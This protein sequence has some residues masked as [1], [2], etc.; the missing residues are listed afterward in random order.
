MATSAEQVQEIEGDPSIAFDCGNRA[1]GAGQPA[2]AISHYKEALVLAPG[3]HEIYNNLATAYQAHGDLA[4]AV[5]AA[6]SGLQVLESFAPLHNTLANCLA[7]AGDVK[8]S[9]THYRRALELD[10]NFTSAE[11]N[12]AYFLSSTGRSAAARTLLEAANQRAPGE[13]DVLVALGMILLDENKQSAGEEFLKAALDL[14]PRHPIAANQL[15]IFLLSRGRNLEALSMFQELVALNPTR[16]KLQVNLGLTLQGLARN[17]EAADV[18]RLAHQLDP[19]DHSMLS[20]YMQ[21]LMHECAWDE[22]RPIAH[23]VL[24]YL[25]G[26]PEENIEATV[27]PFTLA[28]T[29][30]EPELQLKIARVFSKRC[31]NHLDNVSPE[32]AKV[33]PQRD[34]SKLRIGYVSPDFRNHSLGSSFLHLLASHDTDRFEW[35]GYF[36]GGEQADAGTESFKLLFDDWR[37]L[38]KMSLAASSKVIR[39]DGLDIVVDLAGHTKQSGLE[40]FAHNPAPIQAHYL[41]YGCTIGADCIHYLITDKVHT[42]IHLAEFCHE[43]LVYLPDSFFATGRPDIPDKQVDR[44]DFDLPEDAFVFANFGNHYKLAPDC[45]DTWLSLLRDLPKSVLWLMDGWPSATANLL[46]YTRNHGVEPERIV[47]G[48]RLDQNDHLARLKLADLALDTRPE[49]DPIS[50]DTELA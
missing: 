24:E 26:Q 50:L 2:L 5:D 7:A 18:F 38:R 42:P 23:K 44:R 36:I 15:A 3:A 17:A 33:S 14:S 11:V 9:E 37:D 16:A 6:R 40:I 10:P 47:F 12:F 22:L 43:Q 48:H 28:G 27:T 19:N 45:F 30:A 20:F 8:G 39:E 34:R 13:V 35:Y 41:G 31:L 32:W 25:R 46:N 29:E 21:S 49:S 1:L 4:Q